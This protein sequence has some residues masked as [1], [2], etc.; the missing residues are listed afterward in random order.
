MLIKKTHAHTHAQV[1]WTKWSAPG[2][3]TGA[4]RPD[5]RRETDDLRLKIRASRAT[6]PLQLYFCSAAADDE[7]ARRAEKMNKQADGSEA[8]GAGG[9]GEGGAGAKSDALVGGGAAAAA[10]AAAAATPYADIAS[11]LQVN[12]RG[13]DHGGGGPTRGDPTRPRGCSLTVV[14]PPPPSL[15]LP[16]PVH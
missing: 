15:L 3:G 16:P 13:L 10:A 2:S 6:G 7:M 9:D 11:I 4:R 8:D 5:N 12:Y 1:N 14:V